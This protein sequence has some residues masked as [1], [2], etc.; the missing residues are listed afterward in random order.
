MEVVGVAAGALGRGGQVL[1]GALVGGAGLGV[2]GH[3]RVEEDLL[4]GLEHG[5][6]VGEDAVGEEEG[7]E[8]VN[9]EEAEV[10]QPLEEALRGRVADLGN[11]GRERSSLTFTAD[12]ARVTWG[13]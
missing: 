8:E 11:L 1:H 10:G 4:E 13:K 6:A 7:V 12:K 5:D 2:V 9:V 3:V